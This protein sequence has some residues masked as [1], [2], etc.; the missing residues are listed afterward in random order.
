VSRSTWAWV[1]ARSRAAAVRASPASPDRATSEPRPN[2]LWHIDPERVPF[3]FGGAR[4][5]GS[6]HFVGLIDDPS[7]CPAALLPCCPAA[8]LPRCPVPPRCPAPPLPAG[9][10]PCRTREALPILEPLGKTVEVCCVPL[11]LMSDNG[12]PFV[13]VVRT[14]LRRF[15][16]TLEE[17]AVRPVRTQIDTTWTNGKIEAFRQIL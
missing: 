13:A 11:E 2:E 4:R 16:R 10:A 1:R 8:P 17:L 9:I 15:Q 6:C 14:M 5:R 3:S 7:R 12:T